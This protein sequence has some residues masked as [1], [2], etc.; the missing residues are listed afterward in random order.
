MSPSN[1]I[2]PDYYMDK[3]PDLLSMKAEGVTA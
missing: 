2:C 3:L 1:K